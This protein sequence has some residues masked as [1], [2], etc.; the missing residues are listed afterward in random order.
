[1]RLSQ[2]ST[3][4][5]RSREIIVVSI[6]IALLLLSTFVVAGLYVRNYLMLPL[7]PTSRP[8]QALESSLFV[9]VST[10]TKT[11]APVTRR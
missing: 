4:E 3:S 9:C 7:Y 2:K 11:L 5:P 8:S 10:C 1:M 6:K